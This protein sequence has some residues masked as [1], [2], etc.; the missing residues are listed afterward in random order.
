MVG[1]YHVT[2]RPCPGVPSTGG[3]EMGRDIRTKRGQKQKR[4]SHMSHSLEAMTLPTR[5]HSP[6]SLGEANKVRYP[7]GRVRDILLV[8]AVSTLVGPL[9]PR[10]A[11]V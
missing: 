2:G 10:A 8:P 9:L 7:Q 11:E 1:S 6:F 4:T 3:P 5:G